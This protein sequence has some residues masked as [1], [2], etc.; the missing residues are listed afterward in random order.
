[1]HRASRWILV[2]ALAGAGCS[3]ERGPFLPAGESGPSA[4]EE[5]RFVKRLYLDLTGAKPTAEEL[6]AA[7]ERLSN[8]G[9][10]PATR[11]S[12]ASD[13]VASPA[14]AERWVEETEVDAFGGARRE[15]VYDLFCSVFLTV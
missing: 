1:M 8:E 15:D 14:F 11:A 6:A 7:L 12:L 4:L 13:L 2:V 9:N 10:R 5:E 3:E